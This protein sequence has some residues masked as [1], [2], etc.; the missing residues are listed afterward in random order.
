MPEELM[1][2]FGGG[3]EFESIR[4]DIKF[5]DWQRIANYRMQ[6]IEK[7]FISEDEKKYIN[8]TISYGGKTYDVKMRL[9]GD[10][11][12]H[13][14]GDKWSFRIKTKRGE[15]INGYREASL[16]NPQVRDFQGQALINKMLKEHNI[17]VPRYSFVNVVINGE[18]IGI[19][20][21]AEHFR[22][23]LIESSNRREGVIIK[24]DESDLW[25]SRIQGKIFD[26]NQYRSKIVPF[27]K[28]K[29]M[30]DP[31]LAGYYTTAVGLLRGYLSGR[32]P[33][34][35]VFDVKQM[36][37]FIAIHDLWGDTHALVWH[38][39]RFYYNPITAKLEPIAFD[40]LLYHSTSETT[41]GGI[42]DLHNDAYI[43]L[44]YINTLKTIQKRIENGPYLNELIELDQLLESSFRSEFWLKPPPLMKNKDLSKRIEFLKK[45]YGSIVYEK[46]DND[47]GWAVNTND[48]SEA[49]AIYHLNHG[50]S[51]NIIVAN[52]Y[53]NEFHRYGLSAL[54]VSSAYHGYMDS[55]D[56]PEVN[57]ADTSSKLSD[58]F[59]PIK[60]ED[61]SSYYKLVNVYMVD[62]GEKKIE[63]QNYTPYALIVNDIVIRYKKSSSNGIENIEIPAGNNLLLP[64]NKHTE[65][66]FHTIHLPSDVDIE[67]IASVEVKIS[68]IGGSEIYSV[69]AERYS[70]IMYENPVPVS[71]VEDLLDMHSFLVLDEKNNIIRIKKGEW[72]VAHPIV[73]PPGYTLVS[74]GGVTLSF[75]SNS[76]ILSHGRLELLGTEKYPITLTSRVADNHWGGVML[77]GNNDLPKSTLKNVSVYN[78]TS[79]A[80][81]AWKIDAGVAA[82]K[83]DLV[84][85]NIKINNN[86]CEDALNIIESNFNINNIEINNVA[87]DAID[88]DFS[89]GEINVGH[90]ANIGYAGG[91]DALDFSGS[92]VSL[93]DLIIN[94]IGDKGVSVGEYSKVIAK[95]ITVSNSGVAV[96]VKDGSAISMSDSE[97]NQANIAG[98]MAYTK[99]KPY[100]GGTA[101]INNVQ[102]SSSTTNAVSSIGS[103]VFIDSIKVPEKKIDVKKMYNTIMKSGLK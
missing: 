73:V 23:E 14:L 88:S 93:S 80:N 98:V 78:V 69:Y 96:A 35:D 84:L 77:F 25:E 12:D 2:S 9:K 79:I 39:L 52:R 59:L 46:P 82:Y 53:V 90:I 1:K 89:T 37:D 83:V 103:S 81:G 15:Y 56:N 101:D 54:G 28:R 64:L 34:K 85:Q 18:D 55:L 76:Y 100:G 32:L 8:G 75:E 95:K 27:Q 26:E 21:L 41:G 10:Y 5:K 67:S 61:L 36:G 87:S 50:S 65:D 38:N 49:V 60:S 22:K 57:K 94:N 102:I 19:M 16:Q 40:E 31:K 51:E 99:K 68:L 4:I 20:A 11:V 30:S 63:I 62:G 48:E 29:V 7:G 13:L 43:K 17:I 66:D 42:V 97:I 70:E 24:F 44:A 74:D 45:K 92:V 6:A 86:N 91:G 47:V 33:A 3:V 71:L 72:S 58:M